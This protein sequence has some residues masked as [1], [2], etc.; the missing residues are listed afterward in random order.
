MTDVVEIAKERQARLAIEIAK[1]DNFIR[2][3]EMLVK[4]TPLKSSK[5]SETED[6]KAAESTDPEAAETTGPATVRPFS[7]TADGNDAKEERKDLSICKLTDKELMRK[8]RA[9]HGE[10]ALDWREHFSF[11]ENA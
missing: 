9:T 11:R 5:A 8:L 6:E 7:A 2:M 1:L 4:Y 3:A 10:P